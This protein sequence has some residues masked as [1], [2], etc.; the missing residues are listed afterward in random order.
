MPPCNGTQQWHHVHSPKVGLSPPTAMAPCNG[1]TST[2]T[3]R[4]VI[5]SNHNRTTLRCFFCMPCAIEALTIIK[6]SVIAQ[7]LKL[8]EIEPLHDDIGIAKAYNHLQWHSKASGL[9]HL[10]MTLWCHI[11][12]AK[13]I[14]LLYSS[15]NSIFFAANADNR[16]KSKRLDVLYQN[17]KQQKQPKQK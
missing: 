11:Q 14:R 6:T 12:S 15:K 2:S 4:K 9:Q 8:W 17:K 13:A 3:T 16:W 5:L 1:T 7:L 10:A